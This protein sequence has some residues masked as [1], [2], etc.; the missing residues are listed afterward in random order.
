MRRGSVIATAALFACAVLGQSAYAAPPANDARAKATVLTLPAD[1]TGTTVEATAETTDPQ[2]EPKV[3]ETVWYQFT[4][5]TVGTISVSFQ[6]DGQLDAGVAVYAQEGSQLKL[7]RCVA[8]DSK[9]H[10]ALVFET[11][12]DPKAPVTYLLRVGQVLNSDPGT[13]KLS[14]LAPPRPGNDELVGATSIPKLPGAV[15]GTTVGATHDE[16]DPSCTGAGATVWY[17][18]PTGGRRHVRLVLHASGDLDAILCAVERVRSQLRPVGGGAATDDHGNAALEFDAAAGSK[19]YVVVAQ[20]AK[21]GPGEFALSASSPPRPANDERRTAVAIGRLPTTIRATTVGATSN[22]G[23][24]GCAGTGTLWYR[25]QPAAETNAVVTVTAAG[26]RK[27]ATCIFEQTDRK[28]KPVQIRHGVGKAAASMAFTAAA[29]KSYMIVVGNAPTTAPGSFALS[30]LAAEPSPR[31]PGT[32]VSSTGARGRLDP[33]LNT[34]DAWAVPLTHGVTY[35]ISLATTRDR[36]VALAIYAPDT[37]TFADTEPIERWACGGPTAHFFTP[38]PDGGGTYPMVVENLTLPA[39]YQLTVGR[40]ESDDTAPGVALRNGATVS[41]SVSPADPLDFGRFEVPTR[42]DVRIVVTAGAPLSVRLQDVARWIVL[43]GKE[44]VRLLQNLAAGTYYLGLTPGPG[45]KPAH[46]ELTVLVRYITTT[47]LT[48]GGEGSVIVEPSKPV[49]LATKTI[50]APTAGLTRLQADFYDTAHDNWIFRRLWDVQPNS[51]I[52]FVPPAVGSWRVR[53]TFQ[54]SASA[55]PSRSGYRTIVVR[56]AVGA[57]TAAPSGVATRALPAAGAASA[58]SRAGNPVQA[59]WVT[60]HAGKP[61]RLTLV[62]QAGTCLG[63][64]LFRGGKALSDE[65]R[66]TSSYPCAVSGVTYGLFTPGPGGDGRYVLTI[67]ADRAASAPAR[68]PYRLRVMPAG[69]DDVG[70]A[71]ALTHGQTARGGLSPLAGDVVDLYHF[72]VTGNNDQVDLGL[73]D[74]PR[75]P[76]DLA[77]LDENGGSVACECGSSGPV[78]MTRVLPPGHY[79]A[80]VRAQSRDGGAYRLSLRVHA[81]TGTTLTTTTTAPRVGYSVSLTATV[82]NVSGT[83]QVEFV[84]ERLDP[85]QGWVFATAHRVTAW[86]GRASLSWAPPSAGRW[87]VRA[88]FLGTST[89]TPSRSGYVDLTVR[90]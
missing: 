31:P 75:T 88:S 62:S 52:T 30:L 42:S 26:R 82:S 35:R 21:S 8:S 69:L 22:A 16:G 65:E 86:G 27:Q 10:A 55:S 53:A 77:V 15:T 19:Y 89:A 83:G 47:D 4:R 32:A 46:Y 56:Q 5:T 90:S 51:A 79:Y 72:D 17:S 1:V 84:I 12:A 23:D 58:V 13:F 87:R 67:A 39:A 81:I 24:P 37:T 34:A 73:V 70:P 57:E 50:P 76:F 49:V 41:G 2:C 28:L 25:L 78:A 48:A 74:G 29:G 44:N 80:S 59:W 20:A 71:P 54:G 36:C 40:A 43:P 38:G 9:G 85:L 18:L 68:Q 11:H 7:Q 66:Q 6:G 33:L 45:G 64:T 63:L 3:R 14:V 61:Y 60:M